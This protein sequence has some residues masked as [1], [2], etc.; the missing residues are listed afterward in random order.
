MTGKFQ[1]YVGVDVG[2]SQTRVV[3]GI[4]GSK[5]L[6]VTKFQVYFGL[7]EIVGKYV[8]NDFEIFNFPIFCLIF[9]FFLKA[10]SVGAL[11]EGF[12]TVASQITESLGGVQVL[13]WL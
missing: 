7:K 9:F 1:Y 3:I 4:S 13:L 11:L 12:I 10:A 5:F 2:S 6:T 8:W